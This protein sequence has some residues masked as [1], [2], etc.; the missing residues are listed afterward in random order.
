MGASIAKDVIFAK[1]FGVKE[2]AG[3]VAKRVPMATY[4][5]FLGRDTLTIAG[6]FIVPPMLSKSI[7]ASAGFEK[8]HADKIA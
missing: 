8:K 2:P 7:Q 6:G 4:A 5:L 3:S 1:L